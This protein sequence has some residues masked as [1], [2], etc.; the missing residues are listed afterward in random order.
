MKNIFNVIESALTMAGYKLM[1]FDADRLIV[2]D[3]KQDSDY[4]IIVEKLPQ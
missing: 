4:E 3:S 1:D 2:R